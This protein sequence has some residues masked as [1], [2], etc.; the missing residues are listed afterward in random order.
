MIA[1]SCPACGYD[2]KIGDEFAGRPGQC[3]HCRNIHTVPMVSTNPP[4]NNPP[5]KPM[6]NFICQGCGS[7]FAN[8]TRVGWQDGTLPAL[9]YR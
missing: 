9:W 8:R 2:V 5:P 3:W 6:I 1:Y 7:E 4:P